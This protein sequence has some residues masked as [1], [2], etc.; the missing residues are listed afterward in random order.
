MMLT[1]SK[2]LVAS[3]RDTVVHMPTSFNPRNLLRPPISS[4]RNIFNYVEH[5]PP[6]ITLAKGRIPDYRRLSFNLRQIQ[7]HVP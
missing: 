1:V 2:A 4:S 7:G 6:L 3:T 5:R